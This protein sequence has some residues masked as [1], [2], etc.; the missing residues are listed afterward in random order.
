[1]SD[2]IPWPKEVPRRLTTGTPCDMLVGPC[3]CGAT[4]TPVAVAVAVYD[5]ATLQRW[6]SEK[7]ED[8]NKL[9]ASLETLRRDLDAERERVRAAIALLSDYYISD[10]PTHQGRFDPG[11]DACQ[12]KNLGNPFW[13]IAIDIRAALSPGADADPTDVPCRHCG[14]RPGLNGHL[15]ED[16]FECHPCREKRL[17][18]ERA[19]K[20]PGAGDGK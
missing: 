13:Q 4:H 15:N 12:A 6:N 7:T 18:E 8:V 17:A 16:G 20:K 9:A 11:C 14:A 2:W 19:A 5:N 10:C 3:V 1:M